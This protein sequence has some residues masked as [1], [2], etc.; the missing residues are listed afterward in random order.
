MI[1]TRLLARILD[2]TIEIQQIPAP[3][4]A[5]SQRA[6]FVF[7]QFEAEGLQ[8]VEIDEV[9]NVYARLPGAGQ[10]P[11]LVVSAHLDT[12][13][14]VST[15]LDLRR[16]EE[17]I[18]GPGIGD[19]SLG[20]AG[21]FGLVWSLGRKSPQHRGHPVQS[22][23]SLAGDLWLVANIGE[24]GLGNLCG[25]RAV[26]ERFGRSVLA[27]LVIEGMALGQVYHRGLA[28]QRYRISTHT[29]GGHSWVDYGRPSAI[30]ELAELVV[31][32]N[33]LEV[34]AKPRSSLNVGV[35]RG[36]IS[37]NTIASD[38]HLELDLRSESAAS[39]EGLARQVVELV[40]KAGKP[41]VQICIEIIGER[42]SGEIPA[43]HPLVQL[44][45]RC[46]RAQGLQPNLT[47]GSTDAN[48]P[49]S[50]GLPAVCLGLSTG[51]GAHTTEEFIYTRPLASG[52][53]QLV[54]F[55]E[56]V[57]TTI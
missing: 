14:P 25:M 20:V 27:Y 17:R 9:G 5:E 47:I 18:C 36:G 13:F 46:L 51:Y 56:G 34:P 37:I 49:L 55:V 52:V 15:S 39:L 40:A 21:L 57:F 53:A 42:P 32:L 1:D 30:H 44:A 48:I 23:S 43:T 10:A 38:A 3:S 6:Q 41:G 45:K 7:S 28:V 26:V 16:D 24:E 8:N 29:S 35:I 11:P 22:A 31:R 50:R 54:A 2:R 33:A 12:V 19:N 4:L